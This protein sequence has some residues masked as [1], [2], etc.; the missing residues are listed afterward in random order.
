MVGQQ[1][2]LQQNDGVARRI[3]DTRLAAYAAWTAG[4]AMCGP[5]VS[6]RETRENSVAAAKTPHS[7]IA[8]MGLRLHVR[9]TLGP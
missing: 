7:T 4:Y 1:D 9:R 2:A 8:R 5:A 6:D 3:G